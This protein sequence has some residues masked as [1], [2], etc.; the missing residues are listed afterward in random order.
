MYNPYNIKEE[1]KPEEILMYLR[2]S[3]ADDPLKSVEEVVSHH[4]QKIDEWCDR[5]LSG[6]IPPENRFREI[7]SGGDSIADRP[8]FQHILQLIESSKYR[9]VIVKE[10]ARLGRPDTMEI[11][12]ISKT[13]RYTNTLAIA[14]EPTRIFNL[15]DK[16][17][18][19]M[20]EE[21]LK[22]S[23][24]YLEYYKQI[25]RAGVEISVRSGNYI[26]SRAPYAYEK[27]TVVVDKTKCPTLRIKEDE[28]DIVRMIFDAYVNENVGT[29]TIANRLNS[30]NIKSPRGLVWTPD[31][32]RT[33]IEN[34]H[35][36]GKV[37]WN[38]RKGKVIVDNGEF[39]KTRP[40]NS[41]DD[42]ILVEG[43][44][45][46]IISEELF[47]A[48][49]EK[50]KRTHRTCANKELKN[51][52]ASLLFCS[53]GKAMSYRL[54]KYP[55]GEPRGEARFVCNGQVICGSG[56]CQTY[57]I[58]E[59]VA[60][61]LREKI[62]E[63]EAEVDNKNDEIISLHDKQIACLEKTLAEQDAREREMW[64]AQVHP[65]PDKHMPTNVFKD[66]MDELIAEREKTKQ[67]LEHA[68]NTRP[69]PIDYKKKIVTFQKAL[70][71][72]LD[73][74]MSASE[75]NL[76]LKECIERI[77]YHREKPT[78]ITGKGVGRQWTQPPIELDIK[79]KV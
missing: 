10:V 67:A 63:F 13:F 79:L 44:H 15:D 16:F 59:F 21:E 50:R 72:L 68:V 53:C 70:D 7:I 55:S 12:R 74:N 58:E 31:S 30:L 5:N 35:Y 56:S 1:I 26:S 57:E 9:A 45:D 37:R 66:L 40:I 42:F 54:R 24:H 2:K 23:A 41:D 34:I 20:F 49:Q 27:I 14:V 69:T 4:E 19:D 43:K 78:K 76:L 65:N 25:M 29:Q 73:D 32:I 48:A 39:R 52:F 51:P 62:A 28:A 8:M 11:G 61:L 18:R 46:A 60:D 33:I 71:A 64:R 3:R 38:M 77:E 75:K 47:Y 22:R 6:R 17:E 36:I